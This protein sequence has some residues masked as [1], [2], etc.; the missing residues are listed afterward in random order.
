MVFIK[1]T[2]HEYINKVYIHST[3]NVIWF[4]VLAVLFCSLL[5]VLL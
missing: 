2:A 1:V 5:Y 4:R 3:I